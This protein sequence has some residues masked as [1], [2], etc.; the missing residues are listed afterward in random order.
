[1]LRLLALLIVASLLAAAVIFSVQNA[2]PVALQF[3]IFRS[4]SLPVGVALGFA[5]ALGIVVTALVQSFWSLL[6]SSATDD[7][8]GF[9]AS[10]EEDDF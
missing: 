3:L 6:S 10:F 5:V 7:R 8:A 1:M 9:E 4:V 2:A